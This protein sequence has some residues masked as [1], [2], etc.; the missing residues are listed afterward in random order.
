MNPRHCQRGPHWTPS[1]KPQAFDIQRPTRNTTVFKKLRNATNQFAIDQIIPQNRIVEHPGSRI[2]LDCQ[3]SRFRLRTQSKFPSAR[4][5]NP[6]RHPLQALS[7]GSASRDPVAHGPA[8]CRRPSPNQELAAFAA[9]QQNS[10]TVIQFFIATW[11]SE[12]H[13]RRCRTTGS[14]RRETTRGG[15]R[16]SCRSYRRVRPGP[17]R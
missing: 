5:H 17:S 15:C 16:R 11:N 12:S 14:R 2:P 4:K 13:G 9:D 3:Y 1:T 6:G 7:A 8:A 10:G